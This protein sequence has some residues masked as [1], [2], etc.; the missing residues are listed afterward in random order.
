MLIFRKINI[1]AMTHIDAPSVKT[2]N[3]PDVIPSAKTALLRGLRLRCPHCGGGKL[4]RGY[5]SQRATCSAC[6]EE[7]GSIRADDAP[8][9]LTI[10]LTGHLVVPLLFELMKHDV[11]STKAM[12]AVSL[13]FSLLCAAVILPR[14]KGVFIAA[15]W[16]IRRNKY[17]E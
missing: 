12:I 1:K 10:L 3:E 2:Q 16:L 4:L 15:L 9:W 11:F 8:P 14:A 7:L 17:A 13:A 5:I 6:N